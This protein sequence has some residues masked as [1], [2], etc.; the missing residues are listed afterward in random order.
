[1]KFYRHTDWLKICLLSTQHVSAPLSVAVPGSIR[2]DPYWEAVIFLDFPPL[3]FFRPTNLFSWILFVIFERWD[4]DQSSHISAGDSDLIVVLSHL[5]WSNHSRKKITASEKS[6]IFCAAF[7][8]PFHFFFL[9][10]PSLTLSVAFVRFDSC[11]I[12]C[13]FRVT[14]ANYCEKFHF[15]IRRRDL[16]LKEQEGKENSP[17]D[18]LFAFFFLAKIEALWELSSFLLIRFCVAAKKFSFADDSKLFTAT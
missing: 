1:M 8:L 15:Q 13:F 11:C 17:F 2:R 16:L 7:F 6:S 5:S 3:L 12:D 4:L 10:K 14:S 18:L 9:W